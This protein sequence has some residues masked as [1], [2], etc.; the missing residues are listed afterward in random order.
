MPKVDFMVAA[1]WGFVDAVGLVALV[2]VIVLLVDGLCLDQIAKRLLLFRERRLEK[3]Y[4]R[5]RR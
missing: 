2:Y 3:L 5:F 4:E 1:F